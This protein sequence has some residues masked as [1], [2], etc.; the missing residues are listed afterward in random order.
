MTRPLI[1]EAVS[2]LARTQ[3]D[4]VALVCADRTTTFGQLEQL[5]AA[6]AAL[7]REKGVRAGDRVV[8]LGKNSDEYFPVLLG[9][10]R[11][12]ALT[13]PLNWRSAEAELRW[14]FEDA[15]PTLIVVD[16]EFEPVLDRVLSPSARDIPRLFTAAEGGVVGNGDDWL[17][18]ALR[19]IRPSEGKGVSDPDQTAVVFYTSGTT[20][21]PK[22]VM[23][24]HGGLTASVDAFADSGLLAKAEVG[25]VLVSPLHIF[26]TGGNNWALIGLTRAMTTVVIADQSPQH[27]FEINRRHRP[28]Y[29][30]TVPTVLRRFLAEVRSRGELG[31]RPK[32]IGYGAG[33][34][35]RAFLKE[36]HEVL[37]TQL[38]ST[39]GMTEISGAATYIEWNTPS[40]IDA[41][42]GASVGKALDGYRIEI[43]DVEGKE[44]AAR[45]HGEIWISSPSIFGGYLNLPELRAEVISD[46]WYRTG[47][48]GYLDE[49]G[50]L[51]LTD[52]LKDM[53]VTGGENVYPAEVE[54]ALREH[55]D[56][57]DAGVV[58]V[59][60]AAW[61]ERVIGI[62]ECVA[63]APEPAETELR[64]L[65]RARLAAYKIPKEILVVDALPRTAQGKI[66]RVELRELARNRTAT[67][68]E[69]IA[70]AAI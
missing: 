24:T 43:R 26:H 69:E 64:E 34:S 59:V 46:G 30:F 51:Y 2:A 28:A 67:N 1:A 62:V 25:D 44:V 47:D 52:R 27:I 16:D 48:G 35:D 38:V 21:R 60:D 39:F 42:S 22:G 19:H 6:F 17:L 58:G 68:E 23:I 13:V 15:A 32:A 20:G 65:V 33:G 36:A 18:T 45:Q 40:D 54:A 50:W 57:Q 29:T 53:I 3:P 37:Q 8:Y 70:D 14:Q 41:E 66:R 11:A 49:D 61:G 55:P 31:W 10:I 5:T 4:R 56:V 12:G 7:L 9:A 63:G